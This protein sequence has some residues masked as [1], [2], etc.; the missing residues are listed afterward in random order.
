MNRFAKAD[1][2]GK[3]ANLYADLPDSALKSVGIFKMLTGGDPII[4]EH[5]FQNRFRL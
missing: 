3:L 4:G 5:N 2:Y 1:L